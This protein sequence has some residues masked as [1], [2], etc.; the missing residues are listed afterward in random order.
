MDKKSI[1]AQLK[2]LSNEA[3]QGLVMDIYEKIEAMVEEELANRPQYYDD[4]DGGRNELVIKSYL[5]SPLMLCRGMAQ[6][7]KDRDTV[8]LV[9]TSFELEVIQNYNPDSLGYGW[10]ALKFR[11]R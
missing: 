9:H 7:P 8:L 1:E 2:E 10:T 11:R 4:F 6:T 3:L 5:D